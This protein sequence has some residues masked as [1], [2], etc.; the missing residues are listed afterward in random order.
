V[1]PKIKKLENNFPWKNH[2]LVVIN[3]NQMKTTLLAVFLK[4]KIGLLKQKKLKFIYFFE[5]TLK[6]GVYIGP[7]LLE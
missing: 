2:N 5:K 7:G 6:D 4:K 1:H 3:K